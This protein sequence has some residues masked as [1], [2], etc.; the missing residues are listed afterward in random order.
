ML[1]G[2]CF[3]FVICSFISRIYIA[4]GCAVGLINIGGGVA[5]MIFV[6]RPWFSPC[7]RRSLSSSRR[8]P[9]PVSTVILQELNGFLPAYDI[10]PVRVPSALSVNI[11]T[12]VPSIPGIRL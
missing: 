7:N 4:A 1:G 8:N 10:L 5:S 3:R 11:T 2:F 9:A 6:S 12:L